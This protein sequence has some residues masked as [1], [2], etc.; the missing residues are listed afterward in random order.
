MSNSGGPPEDPA[1]RDALLELLMK[2]ERS[3]RGQPLMPAWDGD[4]DVS[5]HVRDIYAYLN[6]RAEGVLGP[7]RPKRLPAAH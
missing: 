4:A 5:P 1:E 2:R 6:A 7:G 3:E